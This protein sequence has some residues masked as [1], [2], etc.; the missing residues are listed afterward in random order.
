MEPLGRYE[1]P[2]EVTVPETRTE[3]QIV[4]D[5]INETLLTT[6]QMQEQ[7]RSVNVAEK[8]M[9]I[10]IERGLSS[11][12]RLEPAR[13]EELENILHKKAEPLLAK[14]QQLRAHLVP[15]VVI[16]V[17]QLGEDPQY[18]VEPTARPSPGNS[19]A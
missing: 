11:H 14:F 1:D 4:A 16:A 10:T 13:Y 18:F 3:E 15:C 2:E 6:I 17:R 8:G 5:L 9:I 19:V 7:F 12:I